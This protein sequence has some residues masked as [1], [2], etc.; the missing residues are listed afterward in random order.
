MNPT[1][2]NRIF[3]FRTILSEEFNKYSEVET[4][5]LIG[6]YLMNKKYER[7][8]S[9]TLSEFLSKI[10]RTPNKKTL[11]ASIRK[12]KMEDMIRICRAGQGIKMHLTMHG[13]LYLFE[14]EKKLK[15]LR[16]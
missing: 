13:I 7:C 10:H 9:K 16:V 5:V 8:S 14:L 12:F 15:M 1:Q 4:N 3:F 6:I 2:L 11:L